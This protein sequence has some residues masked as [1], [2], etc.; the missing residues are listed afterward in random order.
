MVLV[1]YGCPPIAE[2]VGT[3][4]GAVPGEAQGR[5]EG[6]PGGPEKGQPARLGH[7]QRQGGSTMQG[8]AGQEHGLGSQAPELVEEWPVALCIF[9]VEPSRV[10]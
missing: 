5:D 7:I 9:W 2:Q 6:V 8:V 10:L 3:Q 1:V 4:T